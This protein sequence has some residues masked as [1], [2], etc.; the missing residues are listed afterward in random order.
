MVIDPN[1]PGEQSPSVDNDVRES[2]EN[3]D[4]NNQQQDE[5]AIDRSNQES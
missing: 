2:S 5:P 1:N 4:H 3:T